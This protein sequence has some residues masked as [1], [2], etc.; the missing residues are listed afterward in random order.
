[1]RQLYTQKGQ[2]VNKNLTI[3]KKC[4]IVKK[5]TISYGGK[6]HKCQKYILKREKECIKIKVNKAKDKEVL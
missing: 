2:K 1:M 6:C 4:P 5:C 3:G